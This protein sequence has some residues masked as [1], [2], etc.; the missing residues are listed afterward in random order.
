MWFPRTGLFLTALARCVTTRRDS[1]DVFGRPSAV[2][3]A[4]LAF[5]AAGLCRPDEA[6]VDRHAA[7]PPKE[8]IA[9]EGRWWASAET[10]ERAGFIWGASD[11]LSSDADLQGFWGTDEA[12]DAAISK[13]YRVHLREEN[14][15]IMEVWGK[16]GS[17]VHE[18]EH[19][20]GGEIYDH[21]HGF[22][23]GNWYKMEFYPKRI[24]YLQG[25]LGCLKT[26]VND[27]PQ[28]YSHTIGYYDDHVW[29]Y[30]DAHPRAYD[31]VVAEMLSR[32]RD[33]TDGKSGPLRPIRRKYPD[34]VSPEFPVRQTWRF[35]GHWWL[36]HAE[37][38]ERLGFVEGAQDCMTWVVHDQTFSAWPQQALNAITAYYKTHTDDQNALVLNVWRALAPQIPPPT[39]AQRRDPW[40][41]KPKGR[42]LASAWWSNER[43]WLIPPNRRGGF[44]E[45]YIWCLLNYGEQPAET[46]SQSPYAYMYNIGDYL[47]AHP[48]AVNQPLADLL[49]MFR[50]KAK[51]N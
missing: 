33:R 10:E 51:A 9:Y 24:G 48:K 49:Y 5:A 14:L 12:I 4:V 25:Y 40:T 27:P 13:Y 41:Q 3:C 7:S 50:D 22:L 20:E 46:Y 16:V 36:N 19:P 29:D 2:L 23:D 17:S 38:A 15:S 44:V 8:I 34:Y 45:G 30:I 1:G 31:E 47:M 21:P 39:P 28:S 35:D 37:T 26:Y 18:P 32:F 6:T 43:S 42:Y 11:C